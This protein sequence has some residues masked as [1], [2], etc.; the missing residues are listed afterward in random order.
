MNRAVP[1]KPVVKQKKTRMDRR[2]QD[3]LVYKANRAEYLQKDMKD[4]FKPKM[5]EKT[6]DF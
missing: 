6:V 2:Y 5:N 1:Q 3:T 4:I